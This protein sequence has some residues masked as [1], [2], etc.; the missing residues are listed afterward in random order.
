MNL[1]IYPPVNFECYNGFHFLVNMGILMISEKGHKE[2][3]VEKR[4][5]QDR[6]TRLTQVVLNLWM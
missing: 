5:F 2:K 6:V 3:G 4:N 1:N